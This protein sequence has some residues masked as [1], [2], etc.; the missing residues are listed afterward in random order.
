[1][2]E[3]EHENEELFMQR[4]TSAKM[5]AVL[6]GAMVIAASGAA[7]AQPGDYANY[8]DVA[9]GLGAG[10]P[11]DGGGQGLHAFCFWF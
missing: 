8:A 11:E 4:S 5:K 6:A 9:S 10:V 2:N 3:N 7:M 1:M